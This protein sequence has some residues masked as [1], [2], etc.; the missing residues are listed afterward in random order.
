MPLV[1]ASTWPAQLAVVVPIVAAYGALFLV[2][3]RNARRAP[4]GARVGWTHVLPFVAGV[5]AVL[6]AGAPPLSRTADDTLLGHMLQHVLLA[7]VA[8]A[9]LVLGL[10]APLLSLGLP[11][12][13]LRAVAPGGRWGGAVRRLTS[14]W[15][16]VG[17]F[18]AMQWTWAVPA[19]LEATAQSSALHLLQHALLFYSGLLLWWVVIDPLG[20]RRHAP[21]IHRVVL[22][23][24]SRL[25]TVAVC[26]PLTFLNTELFP[27]YA[28]KAVARGQDPIVQ[29]QLAGAAMCL[30]E[31]VVFGLA[32]GAVLIDALRREE[33]RHRLSERAVRHT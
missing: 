30:L 9:L 32:I 1:L 21:G 2:L 8:G 11:R 16:A 20:H 28:A 27:D 12:P 19:L 3:V 4:S 29:Q 23:G 17:L 5:L 15:L 14:P 25:A 13:L 22:V 24:L 7:D 26:L 33:R 31:V 10:R 18:A 6:A